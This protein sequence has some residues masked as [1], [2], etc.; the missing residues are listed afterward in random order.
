M[1]GKT[2]VIVH[3]GRGLFEGLEPSFEATRYHSLVVEEATLD[4]A[5]EINARTPDGVIMAIKHRTLPI[6]GVQF[7]PESVLTKE[8]KKLLRNFLR[9]VRS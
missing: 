7:H 9:G 3:D 2:S 8:G 6:D 4:E 1:H 5:F